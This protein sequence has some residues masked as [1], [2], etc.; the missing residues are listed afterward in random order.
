MEAIISTDDLQILQDVAD[1]MDVDSRY[2]LPIPTVR[3]ASRFGRPDIARAR[4]VNR[5]FC[6]CATPLLFQEFNA[7]YSESYRE[8]ATTWASRLLQ[9]SFSPLANHIESIT[10]GFDS[11]SLPSLKNLDEYLLE[12][13]YI[14]PSLI[15]ACRKLRVLDIQSPGK[16]DRMLPDGI[17]YRIFMKTLG[18]VF[19]V[20]CQKADDVNFDGIKIS[21]P[22]T[23]DYIDL[24]SQ[25][26]P[27]DIASL[28]FHRLMRSIRHLDV[29]VTDSSGNGGQRYWQE[30]E[31]EGQVKYP[32]Q[33]YQ[34]G[35][36]DFIGSAPDLRS[37]CVRCTHVLDFDRLQ[38][39]TLVN[40]QELSLSRVQMS[41]SHF[42]R[43][44]SQNAS[45]LRAIELGFVQLDSGTWES[46]LLQLCS[47]PVLDSFFMESC[48]YTN[49]GASCR[50][51]EL[52]L[53]P[54]DDPRSIETTHFE[55]NYG[56]GHLQRHVNAVR[57]K[58]RLPLYTDRDCKAI[59]LLEQLESLTAQ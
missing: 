14:L 9:L 43:L 52:L 20:T 44:A 48:G 12:G 45:T 54:P 42:L 53:P 56:L 33:S 4:L 35:F 13:A 34:N 8:N 27:S 57:A 50:Y 21:L 6:N 10:I 1:V 31:S 24:I 40:L 55:D 28:S 41:Q 22:C 46:T 47:L 26:F 18:Q 23:H 25:Q 29:T 59:Q 36:W 39:N 30:S 3:P 17:S 11:Y 38:I 51:A 49:A 5:T 16:H 37:L 32:N 58:A 15:S 19:R 7:C 2:V